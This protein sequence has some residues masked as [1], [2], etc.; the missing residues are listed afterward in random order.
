MTQQTIEFTSAVVDATDHAYLSVDETA[1]QDA[2]DEWCSDADDP[3]DLTSTERLHH[4]QITDTFL[5]AFRFTISATDKCITAHGE[6]FPARTNERGSYLTDQSEAIATASLMLQARSPE[7][8]NQ[9]RQ[10]LRGAA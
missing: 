3:A 2:L 7:L 8:D 5:L 10:M 1:W 6:A 9:I 4:V